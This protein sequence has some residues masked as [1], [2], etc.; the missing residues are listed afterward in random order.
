MNDRKE[1]ELVCMYFTLRFFLLI[2]FLIE[3]F[4]KQKT[5]PIFSMFFF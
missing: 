1:K 5:S 2:I 3:T 4:K